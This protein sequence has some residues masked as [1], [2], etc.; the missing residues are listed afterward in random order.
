MACS[1][2]GCTPLKWIWESNPSFQ[3]TISFCHEYSSEENLLTLLCRR[4]PQHLYIPR[5]RRD[6]GRVICTATLF[7]L[8]SNI[9]ISTSL[10]EDSSKWPDKPNTEKQSKS[11]KHGM[12]SRYNALQ[13]LP[14]QY[15]VLLYLQNILS[16]ESGRL[17][18]IIYLLAN[19]Q[20]NQH[21]QAKLHTVSKLHIT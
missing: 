16:T 20:Q 1:E 19:D 7:S 9:L 14:K 4:E 10:G 18:K 13:I 15:T 12:G 6:K 8:L 21:R 5:S 11:L 17:D 3:T 2:Y